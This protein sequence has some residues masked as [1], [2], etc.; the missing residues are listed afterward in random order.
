M[1]KLFLC[2][3]LIVIIVNSFVFASVE[4]DLMIFNL[5][6]KKV[7][8]EIGKKNISKLEA[9]S[10]LLEQQEEILFPLL[11]DK[12]MSVEIKSEIKKSILIWD[13]LKKEIMS[14]KEDK[15][16]EKSDTQVLVDIDSKGE[17][18]SLYSIQTEVNPGF[19]EQIA[20]HSLARV[21]YSEGPI[22]SVNTR[23][24]NSFKLGYIDTDFNISG[25]KDHK[26][27][28][29]SYS[30]LELGLGSKLNLLF[31]KDAELKTNVTS[32][33]SDNKSNRYNL[34]SFDVT[35][36]QQ[37]NAYRSNYSSYIAQDNANSYQSLSFDYSANKPSTLFGMKHTY[38]TRVMTTLYDSSSSSSDYGYFGLSNMFSSKN[39]TL[40]NRFVYNPYKDKSQTTFGI[41]NSYRRAD[42]NLSYKADLKLNPDGSSGYW[43]AGFDK[44]M[45]SYK[46][47]YNTFWGAD[48]YGYETDV[49]TYLNF[50]TKLQFSDYS[51]NNFWKTFSIRLNRRAYLEN[52]NS[53]W[54][55][56]LNENGILP[57]VNNKQSNQ[58][59][60]V[61]YQ[62]FDVNTD[63]NNLSV[64]INSK[65][66]YLFMTDYMVDFRLGV[67]SVNYFNKPSNDN[68]NINVGCHVVFNL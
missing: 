45:G 14:F 10:G 12:N 47:F 29:N 38:N 46:D 4:D 56:D 32:R 9:L 30:D 7:N 15:E 5:Y 13:N 26:N 36:K 55:I 51:A 57:F 20:L 16:S 59:M 1:R 49:N 67:N 25:F 8:V 17:Q 35:Q 44:K 60:Y 28:N 68:V 43:R 37:S 31:F 66:P 11:S 6:L 50:Y 19:A 3:I 24:N 33:A 53:L 54:K 23:L 34:L 63:S 18:G 39:K 64:I 40:N 65:Y 42:Q 52:K 62:K 58:S 22:K 21:Q 27:D 61:S 41:Y 2:T 48:Y